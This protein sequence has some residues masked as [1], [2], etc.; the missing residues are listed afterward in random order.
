LCLPLRAIYISSIISS[1]HRSS[2]IFLLV[3]TSRQDL[4]LPL[5]AIYISSYSNLTYS[6]KMVSFNAMLLS[7]GLTALL[8]LSSVSAAPTEL[9]PD[10]KDPNDTPITIPTNGLPPPPAGNP[11]F[12][13]LGRGT[14]NY[15]CVA[16][17]PPVSEGALAMLYNIIDFASQNPSQWN[18]LPN[19]AVGQT[20]DTRITVQGTT[21]V[22]M[23]M[24]YF[25]GSLTPSFALPG[26]LFQ[27]AKNGSAPA[28]AG[29]PSAPEDGSP[30]VPW[31][32]LVRVNDSPLSVAYRVDTAGGNPPA[33]TICNDS[34]LLIYQYSAI[35]AFF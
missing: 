1:I 32:Q 24:H 21:F 23:G 19:D 12:L 10:C 3:L 22:K 25:N 20:G 28:P 15:T 9:D 11:K 14:Q 8:Q 34:S 31:L 5:R 2:F 6:V 4:C 33:G 18:T 17:K 7:C 29:S 27:A 30:A 16:G 13:A 35:Y 26:T